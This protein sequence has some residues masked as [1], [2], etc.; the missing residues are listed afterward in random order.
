[1]MHRDLHYENWL[2]NENDEPIL[3]DMGTSISLAENGYTQHGVFTPMTASPEQLDSRPYSFSSDIWMLAQ[4]FYFIS[5]GRF[6]WFR[7]PFKN[8]ISCIMQKCYNN[9]KKPF[10]PTPEEYGV[11]FLDL[12]T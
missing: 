5:S 3:I 4:T 8:P 11:E 7:D 10:K 1:M 2:V 9:R 12:I 6:P